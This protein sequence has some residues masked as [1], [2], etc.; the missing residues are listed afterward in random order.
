[1]RRAT[2]PTDLTDPTDPTDPTDL[3]DGVVEATN[4]ENRRPCGCPV[5]R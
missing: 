1:V 5:G 4:G 3:T 2:D